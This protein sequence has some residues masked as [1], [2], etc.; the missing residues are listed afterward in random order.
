MTHGEMKLRVGVYPT[1]LLVLPGQGSVP[2]LHTNTHTHTRMHAR[3]PAP[4]GPTCSIAWGQLS[5]GIFV[6]WGNV[7]DAH[8]IGSL[9]TFLHSALVSGS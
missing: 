2:S 7:S 9:F 6:K 3:K 4:S 8:S 5:L 1:S